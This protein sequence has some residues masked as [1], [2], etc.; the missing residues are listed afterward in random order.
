MFGT[1]QFGYD[2]SKSEHGSATIDNLYNAHSL[3]NNYLSPPNPSAQLIQP[4]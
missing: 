1:G 4:I 2:E 3:A